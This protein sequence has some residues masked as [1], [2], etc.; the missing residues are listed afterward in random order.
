VFL[1]HAAKLLRRNL[2]DRFGPPT[3]EV[4]LDRLTVWA[5]YRAHFTPVAHLRKIVAL[6]IQR[7]ALEKADALAVSIGLTY[8]VRMR[9]KITTIGACDVSKADRQLISKQKKRD[10]DRI[11]AAKMRQIAGAR[12][13]AEYRAT[14]LTATRPWEAESISRRTWERRRNRKA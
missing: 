7:P 6:A 13:R 9:L 2:R 12:S 4:V 5:E 11:R 14:G 1:L 8:A 10:R 3:S